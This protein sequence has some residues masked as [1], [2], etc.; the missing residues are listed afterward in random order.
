[1]V[2]HWLPVDP[3]ALTRGAFEEYHDDSTFIWR[4]NSETAISGTYSVR[5]DSVFLLIRDQGS[6]FIEMD[7]L[8]KE[9]PVERSGAVLFEGRLTW[10]GSDTVIME[11]GPDHQK[12]RS[13]ITRA[14]Q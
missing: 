12:A 14:R 1:L 6:L 4:I 2:G 3:A 10:L 9:I 13:I 7:F 5:G 8:P 11:S